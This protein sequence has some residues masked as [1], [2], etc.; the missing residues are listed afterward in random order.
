MRPNEIMEATSES[1][2][3]KRI[4]G[5]VGGFFSGGGPLGA[6]R[7]FATSGGGNRRGLSRTAEIIRGGVSGG[8]R[9]VPVSRFSRASV[10]ELF[11]GTTA[12]G[13][14][15][16]PSGGC[17]SGF[18]PNKTSYMTQEGFVEQGTKCVRNRRRNLSNGRANTR[19]MRRMAAWDKQDRKLGSTLKKIARGR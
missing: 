6:I 12:S 9:G 13:A 17:P 8:A 7:G 4:A 3:H 16:H 14:H 5:A 1:F 19:A 10:P 15:V 18:H 11:G 2:V